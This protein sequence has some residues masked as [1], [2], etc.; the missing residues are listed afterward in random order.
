TTAQKGTTAFPGHWPDV[1]SQT[2][3][4]SQTSIGSRQKVPGGATVSSGQAALVP[5]QNSAMSQ[6]PDDGRHK[7]VAAVKSPLDSTCTGTPELIGLGPAPSVP[8]PPSPQHQA[9]PSVVTA[10]PCVP[11]TATEATS[12]MLAIA[13]GV[14]KVGCGVALPS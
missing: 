8:L 2:S 1:P 7:V 5:V 12:T 14:M 11:P 10:Q 9:L 13:V 3:A 6:E 4:T